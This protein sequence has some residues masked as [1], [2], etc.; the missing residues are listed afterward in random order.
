M[1]YQPPPPPLL[2]FLIRILL[3]LKNELILDF[4]EKYNDRLDL[5]EMYWIILKS[6]FVVFRFLIRNVREA[7][8]LNAKKFHGINDLSFYYLSNK[9]LG[10]FLTH[11]IYSTLWLPFRHN[12][13]IIF[14]QK[15]FPQE[16]ILLRILFVKDTLLKI[17]YNKQIF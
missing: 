2:F 13:C 5:P 10:S 4:T 15:I 14:L 16:S 11:F 12:F 8:S 3:S 6:F 7:W 9:R 17:I 1:C